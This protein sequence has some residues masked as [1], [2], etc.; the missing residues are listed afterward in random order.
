MVRMF[1]MIVPVVALLLAGSRTSA[2]VPPQNSPKNTFAKQA[3]KP[4]FA[5]A[6]VVTAT[7]AAF[8]IFLGVADPALAAASSS[9]KTAAHISITDVPPT[10]VQVNIKDLPVIGNILSGTYTKVPDDL[11]DSIMIKPSVTIQSP[12]DKVAA[13]QAATSGH[14]EF[15]VD[16]LISTH[17]D[18]DL[19]ADKSGVATIRVTSPLIPQL[20]FKNMASSHPTKFG[21]KPSEWN[22]V[23]NLG[24][25]STYYYNK[26]TDVTQFE[27]PTGL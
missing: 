19:A 3:N 18:V 11:L 2:Y 5:A 17:L 6:S 24:D 23:T 9:S 27:R 4:A 1:V 25:G 8:A 20:P 22:A 15:D 21:S 7:A 12:K 13:I 10:S 14:L 26:K 16:G